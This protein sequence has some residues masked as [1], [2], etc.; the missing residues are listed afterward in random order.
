[1]LFPDV[2][3][4]PIFQLVKLGLLVRSDFAAFPERAGGLKIGGERR[5]PIPRDTT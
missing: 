3:F 2:F 5:S 1:M 4:Q